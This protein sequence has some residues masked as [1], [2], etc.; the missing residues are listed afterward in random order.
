MGLPAKFFLHLR[1]GQV[2][3]L[4]QPA[5]QP[6]PHWLGK[7]R[8]AA[9]PM[10]NA[11]HLPGTSPLPMYLPHIVQTD[12]KALRQFRL[13]AFALH[14][15]LQNPAPQI[16]RKRSCHPGL[17]GDLAA[18]N[19]ASLPS[20]HYLLIWSSLDPLLM[21]RNWPCNVWIVPGKQQLVSVGLE[22]Y[23]RPPHFTFR[24]PCLLTQI[25]VTATFHLV[26]KI[27]L[28]STTSSCLCWFVPL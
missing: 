6:L 14:V 22:P 21:R 20:S 23:C 12:A 7:Q 8:L 19:L 16:V 10:G 27:S 9:R 11:L 3:L 13:R 18:F 25:G 4:L 17:S 1:Q 15:G 2:R 24:M 5:A 28:V 26:Q